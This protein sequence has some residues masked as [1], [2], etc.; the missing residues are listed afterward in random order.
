MVVKYGGYVD[1]VQVNGKSVFLQKDYD[2][3]LAVPYDIPMQGYKNNTVNS[4]RLWSAE[5]IEGFDLETFNQGD[6]IKA[7]QRRSDAEAISQVLYPSDA[8]FEG[9]QLRLKQEYFFVAAGLKRIL[10][11]YKKM[12]NG[13]VEGL[14]NHIIIHINDTHPALVVPELMRLLLDEE[15]LGWDEAWK[16]VTETVT[17]TNHTV[18][19]EA[20]EKWP[21][22]LMQRLLPRVYMIIDEINR[23]F[24]EEMNNK[25]PDRWDRNY[26]C[27][28]LQDGQVHMAN[29]SII[30]AHSVNGVAEIHSRILRDETFHGFYEI[31]PE[32][33]TN[34]TNGVSQRRFMYGAN[35][36]LEKAITSKIGNDWSTATNME[37]LKEIEKFADDE[38]FLDE[39]A[40]I[41]RENKERLAKYIQ[42]TQGIEINPDSIFDIQVKRIHE[43][44][45]QL[46]N[47]LHIIHEY[48]ELKDNPNM[49][50][51]PKTYFLAGK[52]APSY[53]YAKEVI[54]LIN[55]VAQKINSD[56]DMKGR[57]SV[58]FVPNFNVSTAEIIYPAAEV[59]EQISTA[60]KEAS[61]TSNMKFMM[62]GAVTLGTM[63]GANI[64]IREHVGDE[65]MFVF[66][67]S[68]QDVYNY[69]HFGGYRSFDYYEADPRIRRVLNQLIDGTLPGQPFSMI[70]D[71][72]L[73]NN[74]QYFVLRDFDDYVMA[75]K[76][77]SEAYKDQ[78]NWHRMSLMNIA[79][80][81]VFSSDRSIEDYKKNVW[82]IED[83]EEE[84]EIAAEA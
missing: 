17:F 38:A 53:T 18:L 31:W 41:K 61:G 34:V 60:G 33:F 20:L 26:H 39:L 47:V 14:Q 72:L 73:L 29:L 45:R 66:G 43:Y 6:F 64:E 1:Q 59:S 65:N 67:I 48:N 7:V 21:I 28:V 40:S 55:S 78:K 58:V 4:L 54:R 46:L 63:D 76:R 68:D 51:V 10:R 8:G 70:Y 2:A 57:L 11:R 49:D 25:Y 12:H 36:K 74:D 80:S 84:E 71:S 32:K 22:D 5:P 83:K 44:K 19:P 24:M 9:R 52:S 23:R 30:G 79:N 77:V 75:Q 13:S 16:I 37:K 42:Q 62:N 35:P 82:K 81:G 56:P 3:I 27:S 50:Y 15:G 69:T